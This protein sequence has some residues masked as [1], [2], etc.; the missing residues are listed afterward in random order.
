VKTGE[1]N[2]NKLIKKKAKL[3][4]NKEKCTFKKEKLRMGKRETRSIV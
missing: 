2:E 3:K 4:I 1:S